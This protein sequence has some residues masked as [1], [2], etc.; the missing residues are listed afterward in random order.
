MGEASPS[1]FHLAGKMKT[2]ALTVRST[3]EVRGV[4][5]LEVENVLPSWVTADRFALGLFDAIQKSPRLQAAFENPKTRAASMGVVRDAAAV[6]LVPNQSCFLIPHSKREK[7]D[8]GVWVDSG[9][10]SIALYP[11][12]RGILD[13]FARG[14]VIGGRPSLVIRGEKFEP[15]VRR[16]VNGQRLVSYFYGEETAL[17]DSFVKAFRDRL[18]EIDLAAKKKFGKEK[19]AFIESRVPGILGDDFVCGLFEFDRKMICD[20][21]QI[22][23]ERFEAALRSGIDR[24]AKMW[25]S[26]PRDMLMKTVVLAVAKWVLP[27]LSSA[28]RDR[29]SGFVERSEVNHFESGTTES[30]SAPP[31]E[32]RNAGDA[33]VVE[34]PPPEAIASGVIDEQPVE[35]ANQDKV[36]VLETERVESIC[37]YIGLDDEMKKAVLRY[38]CDHAD[39]GRISELTR[40]M[41]D[42]TL[43]SRIRGTA[44]KIA[45][46]K[47]GAK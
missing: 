44:K 25:I 8:R 47:G 17:Q 24:N 18:Q 13:L 37:G 46:A 12:F 42:A 31:V 10:V 4:V 28:M 26:H 27:I 6:G 2:K 34:S 38:M 40:E 32:F 35:T 15:V 7:N 43:T 23:P 22:P 11:S 1:P 9:E 21:Y 19:T 45:Q 30:D 39:F 36:D 16:I 41:D 20:A 29:V 14:G 5:S 33:P 3:E